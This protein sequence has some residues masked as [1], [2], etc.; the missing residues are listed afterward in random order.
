MCSARRIDDD[1]TEVQL[2]QQAPKCRDKHKSADRRD[3][4][5]L[6][7]KAQTADSYP[8]YEQGLQRRD[9]KR[10]QVLT[11]DLCLLRH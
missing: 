2:G 11:V 3:A 8:E 1:L 9:S 4:I 6:K 5:G 7:R 10:G